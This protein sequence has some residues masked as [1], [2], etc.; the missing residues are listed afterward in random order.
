[1]SLC[2]NQWQGNEML[3]TYNKNKNCLPLRQRW[4]ISL[5]FIAFHQQIHQSHVIE[6]KHFNYDHDYDCVFY[7]IQIYLHTPI[8]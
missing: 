6:F 7:F 8:Y 5:D 2:P 4:H 3:Y 1:M